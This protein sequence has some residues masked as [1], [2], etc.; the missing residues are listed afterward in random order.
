MAQT[1]VGPNMAGVAGAVVTVTLAQPGRLVPQLLVAVAQTVTLPLDTPLK[2]TLTELP[3]PE[4][5]APGGTVQV[6]VWPCT[7]LV[8]E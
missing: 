3:E 5:V 2:L 4:K 8:M 6:K 1:L 7:A